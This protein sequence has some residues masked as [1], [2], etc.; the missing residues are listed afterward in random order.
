MGEC[1]LSVESK[2][3][4]QEETVAVFST[5]VLVDNEHNRALLLQER[6][7]R[8]TEE[9]PRK[10]VK[11]FKGICTNPSC[12]YWHPPVC[13]KL[14]VWIGMQFRCFQTQRGWWSVEYSRREV[15]ENDQ[16]HYWRSHFNCVVYSKLLIRENLFKVNLENWEQNARS[17]SPTALGTK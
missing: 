1:Y 3:T 12:H 17:N 5:E 10:R 13:Q 4:V 16:L 14:Q 2:R 11:I 9:N 15:V 6:R 8:F 7:H